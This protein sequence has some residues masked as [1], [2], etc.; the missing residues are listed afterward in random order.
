LP[1]L[2]P[3][4]VAIRPDIIRPEDSVVDFNGSPSPEPASAGRAG[5]AADLATGSA[6]S[7]EDGIAAEAADLLD[8]ATLRRIVAEVVREELQG[9]LGER[10]TR[11]VRKLVRREIRIVLAMDDLD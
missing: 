11:N 2:D 5:D 10:I 8:D 3:V 9:S 7:V 1:P 4:R 6:A